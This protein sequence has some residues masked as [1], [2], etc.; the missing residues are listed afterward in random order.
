MPNQSYFYNGVDAEHESSNMAFNDVYNNQKS[1]ILQ[2]ILCQGA[3]VVSS[4]AQSLLAYG[5]VALQ[6]DVDAEAVT[7]PGSNVTAAMPTLNGL[8]LTTG[9]LNLLSG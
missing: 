7:S 8:P 3:P 9:R 2:T 4:I 1:L 6:M 5:L